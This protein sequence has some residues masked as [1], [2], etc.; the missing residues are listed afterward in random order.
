M[1]RGRLVAACAAAVVVPLVLVYLELPLRAGV[2]RAPLV[3][4]RPDTWDGFWY[5]ALAEQFRGALA[6]P[7]ADLPRK[8]GDLVALA[9]QQLGPLALLVPV[10][11]LATLLRQPRVALLTGSAM[12]VTALFNAA[13]SNADIQ[14]Y[15]LGPTLW[16]W[17][18]IGVLAGTVVDQVLEMSERDADD[19]TLRARAIPMALA[20][21][22][23]IGLLVPTVLDYELHREQAN[24]HLD[25]RASR[26]LDAALGEIAPDAVVVSWWS[27]S[28]PLWYAQHVEGRRPDLFIVDDRTRLDLDLGEA[29]DVIAAYFGQRPVYVIRA[30]NHDLGLV[31]ERFL[32][33]PLT[34]EPATDVY[35]VVGARQ[36]GG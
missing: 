24:E 23:G 19:G 26:W 10:G 5:V 9:Q 2:F 12:L 6:D 35:R 25:T 22:L 7:L 27:T 29:T 14:R 16:A 33:E 15:Y 1:R 21:V 4:A 17:L 13:Y 11:F 8:F 34:T 28:T 20:G 31:L 18:W 32:L 36:G 3:Y 30:N